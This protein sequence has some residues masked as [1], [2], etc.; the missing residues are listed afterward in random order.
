[1]ASNEVERG[2][3][4]P[5]KGETFIV[6]TLKGKRAGKMPAL[7]GSRNPI[8]CGGDGFGVVAEGFEPVDVWLAAE[9]RQL[10]LGEAARGSLDICDC[11]GEAD[12]AFEVSAQVG[13]ADELE[14]FGVGSNA[15]GVVAH[16][17]TH[18][19]THSFT[20][21]FTHFRRNEGADFVEPASGEHL[22]DTRVDAGVE[23][24]AR[25]RESDFRDGVAFEYVFTHPGFFTCLT[26][27]FTTVGAKNFGDGFSGEDA[28]FDGADY[29]LGVARS[30]AG[31]GFGVEARE[32]FV[33]V[34]CAALFCDVAQTLAQ[35]FRPRGSVGEAF[36]E[37]AEV[38]SCAGGNDRQLVAAAEIV[39]RKER[40]AAVVAGGENFV[41]LDEVDEMMRNFLLVARENFRGADVEVAIDLRRI[42]DED[43]AFEALGEFDGER[44]F[45][46][47]GGA[48][49]DDEARGRGG[50]HF[51]ARVSSGGA[52]RRERWL[53]GLAR[54]GFACG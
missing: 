17:L 36:E 22:I 20:H 29:F 1:V 39:E 50:G 3:Q 30:D 40:V 15:S 42:A 43:F 38:E 13:V 8:E 51:S 24:R 35:F 46:G 9:P 53:L 26:T 18:S 48:E 14:R 6:A 41:G 5:R 19:L 10:A 31:G 16:P 52:G 34:R 23:G 33:Q 12:A 44:G 49:D 45:A 47:G 32:D 4:N 7:Q 21:S 27:R 2:D 11:H 25:R 54:R 28:H 37:R